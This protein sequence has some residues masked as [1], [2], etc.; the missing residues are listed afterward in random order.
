[1]S[2]GRE[3]LREWNQYMIHYVWFNLMTHSC[4]K[5]KSDFNEIIVTNEY[6]HY[7]WKKQL[8]WLET[9]KT[10]CIVPIVFSMGSWD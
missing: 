7:A 9:Y 1:M 4:E 3:D 8:I 5:F 6:Q 10:Y 2:T